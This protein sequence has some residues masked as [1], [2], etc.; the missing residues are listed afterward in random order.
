MAEEINPLDYTKLPWAPAST[1]EIHNFYNSQ[2]L[3]LVLGNPQYLFPENITEFA[4]QLSEPVNTVEG[5]RDFIRRTNVDLNTPA[6][7]RAICQDLVNNDPQNRILSHS[8][9]QG[10]YFRLND[11]IDHGWLLAFDIDAKHIAQRGLC[12]CHSSAK[13]NDLSILPPDGYPY[14]FNCLFMTIQ[15][16]YQIKAIFTEWGFDQNNISL[17]YSGQ[18]CHVHVHDPMCWNFNLVPRKHIQQ[19]LVDQYKIPLDPVVTCDSS[20]VLRYPGS[21][22]AKVNIPVLK[23][24]EEN[25]RHAFEKVIKYVKRRTASSYLVN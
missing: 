23:L 1:K 8:P 4:L 3:T 6:K 15:F 2:F 21:L 7:L 9:L 13:N 19:I 24:T 17:Y 16:A 18:G 11:I 12:S 25:P 14:C 20:R 22:N 5:A 10:L